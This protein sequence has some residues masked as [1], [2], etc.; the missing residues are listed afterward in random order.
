MLIRII[1]ENLFSFG[2]QKEFSMISNKRLKTLRSHSVE[3][4]DVGILKMSSIYGANGAGKSNL[5]KSIKLLQDFILGFSPLFSIKKSQFKFNE[6]DEP[7]VIAVEFIKAG[8]AYYYGIKIRSDVVLEEELYRSG[9][10]KNEDT[11]IYERKTNSQKKTLINFNK[12]FESEEKNQLF[13]TVLLEDFIE[14]NEPI[15]RLLANRDREGET[16]KNIKLA[17]KWFERSLE[18]MTPNNS[19]PALAQRVEQESKFKEYA[20]KVMY[21]FNIGINALTSEKKKIRDFFDSEHEEKVS[22]FIGD[23]EEN[24]GRIIGLR[25]QKGDEIIILKEDGEYWVKR[26]KIEHVGKKDKKVLFD[27]EEESDG[28]IRLLDFI[29][30]FKDL[31]TKDDKV[32]IIDEIER[33][34]HPVLIKQLIKNF[35][36]NNETKGQLIFSTHES[37]LLD[38][39]IFRQDEIWFAEKQKCGS[40]DLYSLHDFK[41]HKTIDIQKG[42]L[43]GRYGSI[44]FIGNLSDL[45]W[46]ENEKQELVKHDR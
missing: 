14:P 13:K 16:F 45:N 28:T 2:E 10:G 5:I 7:Q 31:L 44:P 29:P 4:D 42:Y 41:E 12:E 8:V 1:I 9:L 6:G 33:S 23:I 20:E 17:Y 27:L 35:S 32:W 34:I 43:S 39:E 37:N 26:L 36:N 18:I 3:F 15:L 38:Q 11:L 24:P 21:S 46:A 25:T 22:K 19:T 30:S 40:T